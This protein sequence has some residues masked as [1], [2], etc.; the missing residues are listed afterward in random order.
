MNKFD[1]DLRL[2]KDILV[3]LN[4]YKLL[5]IEK[6][7]KDKD[8]S[9]FQ[10]LNGM[11]IFNKL[12]S[13]INGGAFSFEY[14][15]FDIINNFKIRLER[16]NGEKISASPILT[17]ELENI[18]WVD[19]VISFVE[20]S[21]KVCDSILVNANPEVFDKMVSVETRLRFSSYNKKYLMN[22]KFSDVKK[23]LKKNKGNDITM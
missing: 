8:Y 5:Y 17:K 1:E 11:K 4:Y 7:T 22:K 21:D 13:D 16:F 15:N 10:M 20:P 19:D 9:V 14:S 18:D 12:V 23:L 2:E 6:L 3:V